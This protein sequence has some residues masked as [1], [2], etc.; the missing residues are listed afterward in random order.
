ML[1]PKS[2]PEARQATVTLT[3]FFI[4]TLD[5]FFA[6]QLPVSNIA[7]PA[8]MNM[9]RE[10]QRHSQAESIAPPRLYCVF[11]NDWTWLAISPQSSYDKIW[12]V[13]VPRLCVE[14]LGAHIAHLKPS[15]LDHGIVA[16]LLLLNRLAARALGISER[17][18]E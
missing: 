13:Q 10:P 11:F 8:C 4:R 12:Q 2:Q 5:A 16:V 14:G 18:E 6:R 9:T 1:G 3:K 7:K 17:I 15:S